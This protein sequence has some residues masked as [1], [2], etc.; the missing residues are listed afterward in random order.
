MELI[1]SQ[2][3]IEICPR[4]FGVAV[5]FA[6]VYGSGPCPSCRQSRG[7][8]IPNTPEHFFYECPT[9]SDVRAEVLGDAIAEGRVADLP[10]LWGAGGDL[11]YAYIAG[12][13]FHGKQAAIDLSA[14][15]LEEY[16]WAPGSDYGDDVNDE[17]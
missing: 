5:P 4:I 12:T 15:G 10:A 11:V 2:L 8:H 6:E 3:E 16:S 9:Y 7:V 13:L 14:P 17:E 1:K